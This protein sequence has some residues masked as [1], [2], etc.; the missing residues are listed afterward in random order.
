MDV[1]LIAGLWLDDVVW[2]NVIADLD[3]AG[4]HAVGVA[5]PGQNDENTSATLDD[6]LD[7][8][9]AAID[10]AYR[11]TDS[12]VLVV[13]HS[14]A[15]ALAWL[16]ADRR[17]GTV[18]RA[19][20]IGGMPTGEGDAYFSFL[21]VRDGVVS[22]PGWKAFEGPDSDDLSEQDKESLAAGMHPMP[23]GVAQGIVHYTD[24]RRFQVPVTMIC[25]EYSPD[26]A[27]KWLEAGDIPELPGADLDLVDLDTGHW[28]M[29]SA[30]AVLADV[31]A[32]LATSR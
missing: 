6:Q 14:A 7:A 4:V 20:L 13:G 19:V 9:L 5:L 28:P 11:R 17:P 21:P 30:P 2:D 22:F 27:T 32:G 1:V 10:D 12:P 23:A 26:D 3:Q 24:P 31:L 15:A 8:V 18:G 25:P 16:A 29:V